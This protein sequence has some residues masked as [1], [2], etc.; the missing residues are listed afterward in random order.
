MTEFNP[1]TSLFINGEEVK[2][3]VLFNFDIAAKKFATEEKDDKGRK[4][5]TSGFHNIY[6]NILQRETSAIVD[7]GNVLQL[8]KLKIDQ[9]VNKLKKQLLR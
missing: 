7:F 4:S 1:I 2:A 6:N 3:K 5:T 9:R 8:T